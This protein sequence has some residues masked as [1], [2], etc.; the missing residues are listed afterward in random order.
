MV[1]GIKNNFDS[2][3]GW[4]LL[5]PYFLCDLLNTWVVFALFWLWE[6]ADELFHRHLKKTQNIGMVGKKIL[7]PRGASWGDILCGYIGVGLWIAV[8][9]WNGGISW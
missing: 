4:H 1:K 8:H 9:L 7:D 6:V 5:G 3:S 2:W